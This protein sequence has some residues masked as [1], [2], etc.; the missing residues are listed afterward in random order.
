MF[1]KCCEKWYFISI[2]SDPWR[3]II[4]LTGL[5][6]GPKIWHW[7]SSDNKHWPCPAGSGPSWASTTPKNAPTDQI[8][9]TDWCSTTHP[10]FRAKRLGTTAQVLQF[11]NF[12]YLRHPFSALKSVAHL[13]TRKAYVCTCGHVYV[14]MHTLA[15]IYLAMTDKHTQVMP[16]LMICLYIQT[17]RHSQVMSSIH[18]SFHPS[19]DR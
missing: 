18:P 11:P 19:F 13:D 10:A 2:R 17:D 15:S 16:Y 1:C 8:Q 7:G 14:C 5:P 9:L 12:W 4:Q 6:L 3:H